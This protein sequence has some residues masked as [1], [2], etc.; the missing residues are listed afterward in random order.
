MQ[1]FEIRAV[2]FLEQGRDLILSVLF[3]INVLAS[4]AINQAFELLMMTLFQEVKL[5]LCKEHQESRFSTG[6]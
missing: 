4:F 6:V 2:Q 3:T 5:S 1:P